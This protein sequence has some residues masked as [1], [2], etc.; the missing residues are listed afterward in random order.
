MSSSTTSAALLCLLAGAMAAVQTPHSGE[1]AHVEPDGAAELGK[2]ERE[3]L[4]GGQ[5]GSMRRI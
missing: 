3:E 1:R 5:D 4:K 2:E